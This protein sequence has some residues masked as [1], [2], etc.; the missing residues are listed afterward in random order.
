MASSMTGLFK[1]LSFSEFPTP[2]QGNPPGPGQHATAALTHSGFSSTGPSIQQVGGS[3][4]ATFRIQ[5]NMTVTITFNRNQSF[6]MQWALNRP[7][8]FP[9]DL[10]NH[11]QGHYNI[12]ALLARDFF[13]DV[14]LLKSQTFASLQAAQAAIT[15]A[16]TNSVNK[17]GAAQTLY[18]NEVHPEQD[19]GRSRG[20]I[21]QAWDTIIR[22]AF[23]NP[24]TPASSAPDGT[25]HKIRL[26]D[27]IRAAGRTI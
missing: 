8:P 24:R 12:T 19:Q 16:R 3:R 1:T 17:M 5:D 6:V 15:A 18:D 25:P 13:V 22:N 20:P 10:L 2:R 21:Q 27:A 23:N 26:V 11:E 7:A 14:M 9:A 4:P